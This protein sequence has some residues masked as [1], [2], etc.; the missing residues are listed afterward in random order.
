MILT[1]A[2]CVVPG[3]AEGKYRV[4]AP[5]LMQDTFM[6]DSEDEGGEVECPIQQQQQYRYMNSEAGTL[7][8][9][10]PLEDSVTDG[11]LYPSNNDRKTATID[12]QPLDIGL[13]DSFTD[14][15]LYPSNNDRKTATIDRQ[16]LDIGLEDSFTDRHLYPSNNDRK[17]ATIDRQPLDIGLEDS[18]TDRHLYPSNNDRKTAT[19]DRQ[20]LDIGL[21]D[22]SVTDGHLYPSNNDRKTATIDRQPLDIRLEDSFTD[23]HLYPSNNDRKTATIDRQPLD[24]G[25]EDSFTDRHLYPSNNDRKTATIDRQPLDIGLEDSVTDGHLYP[26]NNDRKTATID[27]QP[28][29]IGF[30]VSFVVDARGGAMKAK[31]RGGVR[32]IVPPAA[33]AAPTRLTC[34]AATRRAPAAAPP[35]LMEG[36][37]LASR[38]LELQP[39]GAKFLAPVILEVPIYT[40]SCPEREI[41]IL[42]SDTG[43]TWQDH[44]L[45]HADNPMIQEALAK[46][47]LEHGAS[48]ESLNALGERVTRILTCDFPHYLAV[49]SRVRQQVHAVGPEGGTLHSTAIPQ[50]SALVTCRALK[51]ASR[52][53]TSVHTIFTRHL[54]AVSGTTRSLRACILTCDFPH[55]LAVVS[56]VRQQ[57]HAVGPEGGTLHST[58]IPQVRKKL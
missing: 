22:S 31:R 39:Q 1:Y 15:H 45:H 29:G 56:R 28:L 14:R 6:S 38:L 27:R 48:G 10:R 19:I 2:V 44:Y 12:R 36:E 32:V 51:G 42:R 30:L 3:G 55:Y 58:A 7:Q 4:A 50:S 23:R 11:H 40:A 34:R 43:D 13:E 49:V 47:R 46:E 17:T 21:E 18:F 24:I 25:L 52:L 54:A 20:P 5:E 16:P 9:A 53:W 37:A 26:S 35:P 57:V 8:R 33:C 41:V